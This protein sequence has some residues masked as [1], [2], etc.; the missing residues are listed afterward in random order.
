MRRIGIGNKLGIS[1]LL[2]PQPV[3]TRKKDGMRKDEG[4]KEVRR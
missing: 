1:F 2:R 3:A 4:G